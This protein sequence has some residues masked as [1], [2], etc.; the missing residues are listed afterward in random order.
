MSIIRS[1]SKRILSLK[2]MNQHLLKAEYAVRG[3]ISIRSLEI[4]SKLRQG[5][6]FPFTETVQCNIG[7]PH[8]LSQKPLTWIRQGLALASYPELLAHTSIFP[9]DIMQRIKHLL[10]HIRGGVGAYTESQGL[11]VVRESV[12][13]F[14]EQRDKI[15]G[16][17]PAD[18]F[19]SNGASPSIEAFMTASIAG[20]RDG[21]LTPIPQYPLYNA[22]A[23]LKLGTTIGYYL[24][25]QNNKWS[26]CCIEMK[27][28]LDKA[29]SQGITPKLLIVINPGNPTGQ[30]LSYEGMREILEFCEEHRLILMADEVYQDNIYDAKKKFYS[31]RRVALEMKSPVEIASFH[32]ISKGFFGE[33]G[34]RGGYMQLMNFDPYVKDQIF[35]MVSIMIASNTLG[36]VALELALN[37]PK[38]GEPSYEKFVKERDEIQYELRRKAKLIDKTLNKMENISCNDVEGAMYAF[39]SIV[40]TKKAISAAGAVGMSPDK[41]YVMRLLE[42]TGVVVVPGCGFGQRENTYHF[43]ITILPTNIEEVLQKLNNFNEEFHRIYQD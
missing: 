32:T 23:E 15:G 8:Y 13:R 7:N 14:I 11:P 3:D 16:L 2:N 18:L 39:P 22:L 6:K 20:P 5:E 24:D 35:K 43:R 25:E 29:I 41:F 27:T 17:S 34:L 40:F 28:A 36:Q 31:F 12:C 1:Y 42:E 9:E 26:V 19:L 10:G 21:I 37:P 30:V 33:C 4:D 38:S